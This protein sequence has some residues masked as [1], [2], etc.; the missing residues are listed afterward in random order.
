MLAANFLFHEGKKS[1]RYLAAKNLPLIPFSSSYWS[2][3]SNGCRTLTQSSGHKNDL[4]VTRRSVIFGSWIKNFIKVS[5]E[6]IFSRLTGE[7]NVFLFVV[8]FC[9]VLVN[10]T[11]NLKDYLKYLSRDEPRTGSHRKPVIGSAMIKQYF[12]DEPMDSAYQRPAHYDLA[13]DPDPIIENLPPN[14]NNL[15][16]IANL[17]EE[18]LHDL[19]KEGLKY[20]DIVDEMVKEKEGV[21]EVGSEDS[22]ESPEISDTSESSNDM[23]EDTDEIQVIEDEEFEGE[24]DQDD[25]KVEGSEEDEE[26]VTTTTPKPTTTTEKTTTTK[27]TTTSTT[28]KPT[29]TTMEPTTAEK[30]SSS[31]TTTTTP[32]PPT[33]TEATTT[34]TQPPSTTKR[35]KTKK[36]TATTPEPTT[37]STTTTTPKPTTTSTTSTTT[38]QPT[39]T[40]T[41][42][43]TPAPTT[44]TPPPTT[45]SNPLI[46]RIIPVNSLDEI[47]SLTPD[48]IDE[49]IAPASEQ[50]DNTYGAEDSDEETD[51]EEQTLIEVTTKRPSA[52]RPLKFKPVK[53]PNRRPNRNRRPNK[54]YNRPSGRPGKPQKIHVT[55]KG[56]GNRKGGH[57]P[58]KIKINPP[59]QIASSVKKQPMKVNH[60]VTMCPYECS[61]FLFCI[62]F[63]KKKN[64]YHIVI[65]S[66]EGIRQIVTSYQNY[67]QQMNLNSQEMLSQ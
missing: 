53:R 26:I 48:Q 61:K 45:T 2:I 21:V 55:K 36:S 1:K 44:T 4:I 59:R 17:N 7:M 30:P 41:T 66:M 15:G 28:E 40:T 62:L 65:T 67:F 56:K 39:T 32:E 60:V 31:S 43:T 9:A 11:Y 54:K 20:Q 58:Y 35:L 18:Q 8:F 34:T 46:N 19:I 63:K 52:V 57:R 22:D 33:T 16:F 38:A 49:D 3:K 25:S 24:H 13:N 47:Q 50:T 12:N 27:R 42:S 37:T 14:Q 51:V 5:D 29:T 10:G 23:M 64:G 6:K